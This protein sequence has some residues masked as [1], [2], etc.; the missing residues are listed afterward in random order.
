[1]CANSK[2]TVNAARLDVTSCDD[3]VIAR[4]QGGAICVGFS[5]TSLN[6][7]EYAVNSSIRLQSG[8]N[9]SSCSWGLPNVVLGGPILVGNASIGVPRNSA[10]CESVDVLIS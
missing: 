4:D 3:K 2:P 9:C 6:E 10:K 8:G 1:M 7:N 5:I